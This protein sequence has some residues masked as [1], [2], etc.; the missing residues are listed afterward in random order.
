[1][2]PTDKSHREASIDDFER[3]VRSLRERSM[4]TISGFWM[5]I[6]EYRGYQF[7]QGHLLSETCREGNLRHIG[8]LVENIRRHDIDG[9]WSEV[10]GY[11]IRESEEQMLVH[12]ISQQG[13]NDVELIVPER[14]RRCP[15]AWGRFDESPEFEIYKHYI[16]PA[17]IKA[18]EACRASPAATLCMEYLHRNNSSGINI[19][20]CLLDMGCG[21]GNFM[22]SIRCACDETGYPVDW[23]VCGCGNLLEMTPRRMPALSCWGIDINPDNI[24]AAEEKGLHRVFLGDGEAAGRILPSDVMFDTIVFSGLLNRQVISREK[25]GRILAGAINRLKMGGHVIVTGFT[26]CHFTADDLSVMGLSVLQKSF[27]EN[28]FKDYESYA[29]RQLYVA[30]KI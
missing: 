27:P 15:V 10:E 29:L 20:E 12:H 11:P 14:N 1:M 28:I 4:T 30:Q 9:F 18:I 26:S 21:C 25:S 8:A 6:I 5:N 2:N 22:E 3:L 17:I 23:S 24:E 13:N 16:Y 19:G 7:I